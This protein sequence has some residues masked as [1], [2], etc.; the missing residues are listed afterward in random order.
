VARE[1][2][3]LAAIS[4][5]G[6]LRKIVSPE[7]AA[8][9]A[10]RWRRNG[11]RT[12]FTHGW[13]DPLSAGHVHLLEQARGVCDKLVVGLHG[14]A[15]AHLRTGENGPL[16]P[17][18]VRAARLASLPS[19]DLVVVN[20]D[21]TQAGLLRAL[22]PDVLANGADLAPGEV[23]GAELVQEWGGRVILPKVLPEAAAE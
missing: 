5:P 20:D 11:W 8:E 18:A 1:S 10:E 13:F 19:V 2:D 12:G 23:A 7:V 16:Q 15:T 9:R 3:L 6:A 4:P 21:E 17:E 22:R 14:D